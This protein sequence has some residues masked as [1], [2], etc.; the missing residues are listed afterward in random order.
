MKKLF[1]L[2]ALL[3]VCFKSTFAQPSNPYNDAGSKMASDIIA[4]LPDL[5]N[6]T[7]S[8][9]TQEKIDLLQ[10]KMQT[11]FEATPKL[12]GEITA[13]INSSPAVQATSQSSIST[14]GTTL[15][16]KLKPTSF[17]S[18]ASF[19]FDSFNAEVQSSK[20]SDNEKQNILLLSAYQYN[21]LQ[22]ASLLPA[23][24][25]S[26]SGCQVEG[27]QGSGGMDQGGCA[28]LVGSLGAVIGYGVCQWP[29]AGIGFIVGF[30]LGWF[31][32]K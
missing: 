9:L 11:K 2:S 6:A 32:S 26:S 19:N 12:I 15:L 25:N 21:I 5:Q 31:G 23:N 29:C 24:R 1:I 20:I 28:L 27:P 14:A 22:S 4:I 3:F 30:A 18:F 8:D 7:L 16:G 17:Q 10:S 13:Q